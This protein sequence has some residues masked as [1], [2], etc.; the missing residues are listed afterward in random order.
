MKLHND[1][2]WGICCQDDV[3][4]HACM[5]ADPHMIGPCNRPWSMISYYTCPAGHK[6]LALKLGQSSLPPCPLLK[7]LQ[8]L[9]GLGRQPFK[10]VS[11]LVLMSW[12]DFTL[13]QWRLKL[14]PDLDAQLIQRRPEHV[15][16][17]SAGNV[18]NVRVLIPSRGNE[19]GK[20]KR[21]RGQNIRGAV[22]ACNTKK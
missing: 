7:I 14:S 13:Q 11:A 5:I 1:S 2:K 3:V 18:D 10:L 12:I 20:T 9:K 6:S 21:K 19:L 17:Y 8:K 4:N 22:Q 15:I 16:E